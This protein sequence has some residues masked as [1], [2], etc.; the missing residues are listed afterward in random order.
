MALIWESVPERPFLGNINLAWIGTHILVSVGTYGLLTIAALAAFAAMLQ[1][2]ALKKKKRNKLSRQLPSVAASE[3]ILVNLLIVCS[4]VLTLGIIS[5][6]ASLFI[7]TGNYLV[8]D[9]KTVLTFVVFV[10]VNFIIFIH[11]KTGI[12]GK[13]AMRFVM[14]A[15][16]L[17]SLSYPG[18]KFVKDVLLSA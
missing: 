7:S 1:E 11:F 17:L 3:K 18:V 12:R 9:H 14:L 2:R 6:M 10:I 5:G 15:Y 16:L 8:F 13:T 4:I